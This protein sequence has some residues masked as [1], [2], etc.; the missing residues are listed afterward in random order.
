MLY[1][2]KR[3]LSRPLFTPTPTPLP[4]IKGELIAGKG[5]CQSIISK[6]KGIGVI[7]INIT[8]NV[9][10][11]SSGIKRKILSDRNAQ[12]LKEETF[13]ATKTFPKIKLSYND[14]AL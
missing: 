14:E 7:T 13:R 9:I 8:R 4:P 11:G 3:R 2:L 10:K 1:L 6:N 5:N 12:S